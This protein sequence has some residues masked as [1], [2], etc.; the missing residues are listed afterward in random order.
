MN[1]QASEE[2]NKKQQQIQDKILRPITHHKG[3]RI[4]GVI[5]FIILAV[6]AYAYFIQLTRGLEVTAMRDY[7]SW[8]IYISN[9]VFFVAVSLVG[10]LISAV[11]GLLKIKWITAVSRIAEIIAIGFIM[12]A[13]IIIITDMGRPD[14]FP[15]L[16]L[17][18]RIQ[19]PIFWDVT[20]ITTYIIISLLLYLLPLIPDA[21]LCY[22]KLQNVPKWQRAIYKA[23]SFRWIG[24]PKQYKLLFK[25]LRIL[26]ILII[27][28][29]LAIHTVTSWLFASSLRVGWNSTNFGPYFVS[30]AF[31]A[32]VAAVII[33]MFFFR[34]NYKLKEII[35]KTHFNHMGK[36][37][38]LVA[39]VYLYFNINEYL[40]PAYKMETLDKA[41]LLGLFSGKFAWFFWPTQILGL[42]LPIIL[43]LFK[44]M[45][46]PIPITIISIFVLV[47]AWLKRY[48]I[49]IPTMF[50]PHRPIQNVPENF[51][52]YFPTVY[53]ILITLGAF[54]ITF[55]IITLLSK[56]F[57]IIPIWEI[58]KE[59]ENADPKEEIYIKKG[60]KFQLI[61][62]AL[63]KA[64]D[65]KNPSDNDN[66]S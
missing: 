44:R 49:L 25:N 15:Y 33:A 6:A 48:L 60:Q 8:G 31:V 21:A 65:L 42:I 52:H 28:V 46:K 7:I 5:L 4:W 51:H 2:L 38:V 27:P 47:G 55:L 56:I 11:M 10:M 45:R 63:K 64:K 58:T 26:L 54:G 59:Y 34:N 20:V 30:G 14:R 57:P 35:S 50:H 40:V 62:N 18:G 3:L 24:N 41:H 66:P 37:L 53:E 13:G 16:F 9:F 29:A 23:L 12:V 43:L 17:Y 22:K 32:G 61:I 19:S 36:L 1:H 39:L